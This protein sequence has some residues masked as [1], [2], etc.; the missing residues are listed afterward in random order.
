MYFLFFPDLDPGSSPSIMPL[1]RVD[2][3]VAGA[4]VAGEV[5]GATGA[6]GAIGATDGVTAAVVTPGPVVIG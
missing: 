6:T 5:T 4:A 1:Y 2:V 3:D